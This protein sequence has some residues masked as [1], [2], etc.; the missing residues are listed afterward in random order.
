MCPGYDAKQSDSEAPVM[1]KHWGMR[2]TYSLSSF[3]SPPWPGAAV[4]D[5]VLSMGQIEKLNI[6]TVWLY[7]TELIEIELFDI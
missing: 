7:K 5:R 3:L 1:P 4:P 6:S 2:S